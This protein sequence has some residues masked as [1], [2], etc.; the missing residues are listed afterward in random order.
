MKKVATYIMDADGKGQDWNLEAAIK[1]INGKAGMC[2]S[3]VC[4]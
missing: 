1:V 2:R 4:G 3:S